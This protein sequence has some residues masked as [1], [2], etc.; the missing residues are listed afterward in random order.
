MEF[1]T[2]LF[3]NSRTGQKSLV[4]P[5]LL[6]KLKV[7]KLPNIVRVKISIPKNLEVKEERTIKMKKLGIMPTKVNVRIKW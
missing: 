7:D 3:I 6:N 4:I 2:K 5:K 1:L